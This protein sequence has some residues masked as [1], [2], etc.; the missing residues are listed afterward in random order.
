[1]P[2]RPSQR[3]QARQTP[4]RSVFDELYPTAIV[5]AA[6]VGIVVWAYSTF[7]QINW[8]KDNLAQVTTLIESRHNDAIVHSDM[9]RDRLLAS[10]EEL[11]ELTRA[12]IERERTKP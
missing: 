6:V 9:N 12:L 4:R 11:K 2:R 7:A 3:P 1:M 8:V 5:G 10:L